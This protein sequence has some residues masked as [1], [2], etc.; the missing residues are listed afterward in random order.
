M[1]NLIVSGDV[2]GD[3]QGS[4]MADRVFNCTSDEVKERFIYNGSIDFQKVMMLPTILMQEGRSDEIARFVQLSRVQRAGSDYKLRYTVD[5]DLPKLT[6]AEIDS[7]QS[8][9][10]MHQWELGTNHW[11]IKDVNIFEVLYRKSATIHPTPKVFQLSN[12]LVNPRLVSI[13]MPFL[14]DFSHVHEAVRAAIN[15]EG[16][17]CRR[18]DDFWFHTHIMQD[19]VELICTSNVV[20]CDLSGKNSNV[21]YEAGIA[22]TLGK[23]VILITQHMDDVPFDLRPIRCIRY[24]N[25]Q[26]GCQKLAEEIVARLRTIA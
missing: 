19:I 21:F 18:A 7:L 26:E 15:A 14:G 6:N 22:H 13:M 5:H 11:A 9:L 23:Q 12:N 10:N 24:L 3:R 25:N 20:I 8:E 1:F 17:E 16:Y 2:D 4:I